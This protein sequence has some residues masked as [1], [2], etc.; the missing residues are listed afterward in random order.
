MKIDLD[1]MANLLNVFVDSNNAQ[2]TISTLEE[3]GIPIE[4]T[5]AASSS[6]LDENFLFHIQLALENKLVSNQKLESHNLESLGITMYVH[7]VGLT[8][9]PIRLTQKGHDFANAL[10]NK[11][12]LSRLKSEFK[13]APFRMVFDTSQKLLEHVL[14]KKLDSLL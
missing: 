5:N 13:D 6:A 2:I 8:E 12:V 4:S 9:Q 10:D 11:E 7:G 3:Y 1:Y 14:K